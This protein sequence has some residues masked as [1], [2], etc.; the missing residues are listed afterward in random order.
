MFVSFLWR[1]GT[2][3]LKSEEKEYTYVQC[4]CCGHLYIVDNKIPI[5]MSIINSIC[6]KCGNNI[7]L[8]CGNRKEDIYLYMNEN[9]DWRYYNY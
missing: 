1:G 9:L 8:N 5:T 4:Q 6:P 3:W 2:P 7:G